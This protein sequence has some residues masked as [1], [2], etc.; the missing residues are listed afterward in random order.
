MASHPSFR[1]AFLYWLKLG[2]VNFGGPTG[3]IAM[4]HRDLVER[5]RWISEERFLHALNYCM[6]LPG[7]EAQQLAIYVGWLL[8]RAKGGFVAGFLFV[9]PSVFILLFLAWLYVT[10]GSVPLVAA[11]FYGL[12]AV[13]LAVVA[14]AVLRIG[15]RALRTPLMAAI[16]AVAFVALFFL[17][18]PF[19]L[20]VL[21]AALVGVGAHRLAPRLLV[22]P[23]PH[24]KPASA[25]LGDDDPTPP[26]ALPNARRALV[27]LAAGALLWLVPIGLLLAFRGVNGV[28]LD[29]GLFFSKLALVTFG[30]AYAVLA[31]MAQQAVQGH[32]WLTTPQMIAGLG[33]A[34][35][36][37]GPL[38]MVVCFVGFLAGYHFPGALDPTLSGIL[39]GLVATYFTFLFSFLFI[40]LGAPYVEKLRGNATL[41]AALGAIT[42]AVVGVI[43]NLAVFFG[44]HVL[45]NGAGVDWFAAG[46]A[47]VAFGVLTIFDLD[48]IPVIVGGA[49]IGLAYKLLAR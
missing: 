24:G 30:G 11:L 26:H 3:Q 44:Q 20:V 7:P 25:V 21:G 33:L 10:F 28:Y 37:P 29:D 12:A 31:Y 40:F 2:F 14:H 5:K 49:A 27:V 41:S 43:L 48:I 1:E 34:E 45:W 18:V 15:K 19:P 8:H 23:A 4:M 17:A 6:L 38:I 35:S 16:A 13:I 47:A 46:L 39:G 36:T 32:H 9:L 42:A 22:A